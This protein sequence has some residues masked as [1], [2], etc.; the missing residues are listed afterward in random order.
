MNYKPDPGLL[1]TSGS[2]A[3]GL[4][5]ATVNILYM[6]T[7]QCFGYN[8]NWSQKNSALSLS[9]YFLEGED[10]GQ[11]EKVGKFCGD[12]LLEAWL[13]FVTCRICILWIILSGWRFL[14]V[15]Y[16]NYGAMAVNASTTYMTIVELWWMARPL[17]PW[18]YDNHWKLNLHNS[19]NGSRKKCQSLLLWEI[20]FLSWHGD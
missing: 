12:G 4:L 13:P 5:M 7:V 15:I 20:C 19:I 17:L 10:Q 11:H 8:L 18:N 1:Q 2:S 9:H 16:A 3:R 14:F 6:C